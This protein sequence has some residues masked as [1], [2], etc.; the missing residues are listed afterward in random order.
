VPLQQERHLRH[1]PGERPALRD[2]RHCSSE[3]NG[4]ARISGHEVAWV[5]YADSNP[6]V[7]LRDLD[8]GVAVT[9]AS[10]E[11]AASGGLYITHVA[12]SDDFVVWD[13]TVLSATIAKEQRYQIKAYNRL[14]KQVR[15]VASGPLA[16]YELAPDLALS[17]DSLVWADT[18]T[19]AADLNAGTT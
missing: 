14:T 17:G 11:P 18:Q 4:E 7:L 6:S 8:T 9:V 2:R 19:H 13:G 5:A 12:V 16:S 3:Y 10:P 1:R 15:T